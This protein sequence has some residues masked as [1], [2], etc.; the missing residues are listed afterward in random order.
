MLELTSKQTQ[1]I[2]LLTDQTTD[3]VG[4][5]GAAGGGKAQPLSSTVYTPFGKK[6]MGD[7]KVGDVICHPSGANTNV[8]AIHPQGIKKIYEIEFEDGAKTRC[9]GDHL[10]YVWFASEK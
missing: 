7:I 6:K 2:D 3:Y 9:T 10:W 1:A 5:G 4:Y 8:I